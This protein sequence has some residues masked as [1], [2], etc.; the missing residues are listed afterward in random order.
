M[1]MADGKAWGGH[2]FKGGNPVHATVDIVMN[3]IKGGYMK[4]TQ[5]DEIDLELPVPYS[6]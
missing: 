5:D 6:K 3:E 4:W 1:Y 2:F